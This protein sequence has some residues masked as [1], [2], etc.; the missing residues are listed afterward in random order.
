[1]IYSP[2]LAASC[3]QE[4]VEIAK[5]AII[6]QSPAR[7]SEAKK[8][9]M[10]EGRADVLIIGDS[11]ARRWEKTQASDFDGMSVVNMGI[12]G[13][14]TQE[15]RWRLGQLPPKVKP[16]RIILFIGTNNLRDQA[17][18]DCAIAAGISSAAEDIRALWPNA[19]LFIVP[20]LPRGPGFGFR[21]SDR[22]SINRT[23]SV[24]VAGAT[25]VEI[26]EKAL[27]CGWSTETCGNYQP[28]NLHLA[29]EGY[30][31]LRDELHR[32]GF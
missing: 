13:E 8:M 19:R 7:L 17:I 20:V 12:G 27:T 14:R 9:A 29:P 32:S 4:S 6:E 16:T 26:D 21:D 3:D 15:L 1:M 23:L 18:S 25:L 28:D 10:V 31:R 2:S 30:A 22:R 5:T 24:T 11:I